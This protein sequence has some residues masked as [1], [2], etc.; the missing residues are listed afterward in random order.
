MFHLHLKDKWSFPLELR[1]SYL[2]ILGDCSVREEK[3]EAE[4]DSIVFSFIGNLLFPIWMFK[5]VFFIHVLFDN[6][7]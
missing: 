7:N 5:N 2:I 6:V 4:N 3:S 1:G